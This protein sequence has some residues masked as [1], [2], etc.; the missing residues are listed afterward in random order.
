VRLDVDAI[1][2]FLLC[3][4]DWLAVAAWDAPSDFEDEFVSSAGEEEL[5]AI[6]AG[7]VASEA[8]GAVACG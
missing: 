1:G 3:E 6:A 5:S 2:F 8:F 7:D 4:L